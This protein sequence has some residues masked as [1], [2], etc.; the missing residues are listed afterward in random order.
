M[1]KRLL[2]LLESV[3]PNWYKDYLGTEEVTHLGAFQKM[4]DD[5]KM[6]LSLEVPGEINFKTEVMLSGWYNPRNI[7][8]IVLRD[9]KDFSFEEQ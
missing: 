3:N 9:F 7:K 2:A 1:R 5:S 8:S 6:L 4:S